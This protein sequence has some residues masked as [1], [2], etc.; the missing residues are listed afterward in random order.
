MEGR[1]GVWKAFWL[2]IY[3]H[4]QPKTPILVGPTLPSNFLVISGLI[5]ICL[6]VLWSHEVGYLSTLANIIIKSK[7]KKKL[8]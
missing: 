3:P 7:C 4:R 6:N 5:G 8:T 1:F 2:S